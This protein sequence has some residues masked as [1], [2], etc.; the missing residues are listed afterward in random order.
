M[1]N[2]FPI[3]SATLVENFSTFWVN[4]V[5]DEVVVVLDDG[6]PL[7]TVSPTTE[8]T[9]TDFELY[10]GCGETKTCFGIGNSDCI[11]SKQCVTFGAVIHDDGKFIFEM[12][13]SSKIFQIRYFK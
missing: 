1:L 7:S 8:P 6:L 10:E 5:S 3:C 2:T 9:N 11:A 13:S 4:Q 12:R